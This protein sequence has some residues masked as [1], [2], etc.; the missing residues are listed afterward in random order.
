MHGHFS[1]VFNSGFIKNFNID[2]FLEKIRTKKEFFLQFAGDQSF[3][4]D[5]VKSNAVIR[6]GKIKLDEATLRFGKEIIDLSGSMNYF[7]DTL[8]LVGFLNHPHTLNG[9][10]IDTPCILQGLLPVYQFFIKGSLMKP[11]VFF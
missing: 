10:C 9:L 8:E 2:D 11:K 1:C 4:F 5:Q 3:S 7:E 6:N